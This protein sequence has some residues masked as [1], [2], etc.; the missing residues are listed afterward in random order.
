MGGDT[1]GGAGDGTGTTD[2]ACPSVIA[3]GLGLDGADITDF[4]PS[5]DTDC[6]TLEATY[7]KLGD[8]SDYTVSSIDYN[9]PY[10]TNV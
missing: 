4:C 8:T 7:L 1:F 9:P 2:L 10:H 5:V 3:G 6:V